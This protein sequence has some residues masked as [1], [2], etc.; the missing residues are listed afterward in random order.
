MCVSQSHSHLIR[1]IECGSSR[2][3]WHTIHSAILD[4]LP[5]TISCLNCPTTIRNHSSIYS[6][7]DEDLAHF[8][9]NLDC[10]CLKFFLFSHQLD[11]Y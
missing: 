10:F 3:T 6:P 8:Y 4:Q 2:S 9:E 7:L 1:D 11:F 5:V